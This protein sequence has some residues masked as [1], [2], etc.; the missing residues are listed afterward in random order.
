MPVSSIDKIIL[1]ERPAALHYCSQLSL[2]YK[3]VVS[4]Y[5]LE[6]RLRKGS[7]WFLDDNHNKVKN[8]PLSGGVFRFDL[9]SDGVTLVAAL[10][11]GCI[12]TVNLES[13]SANDLSV[14]I[15]S[16]LLSVCISEERLLSSD[17][18]GN[19]HVIDL[20]SEKVVSF[21]AA[22]LKYTNEPCE[23][24]C[25]AWHNDG[26]YI[27]SGG[28]DALLK[29][30]DVRCGCESVGCNSSHESGVT[31][32]KK[33]DEF[34]LLTGSYD[35]NIRRFDYRYFDKPLCQKMLDGG[36]WSIEEIGESK[37]LAACMY[38]GWVLLDKNTFSIMERKTDSGDFILYGATECGD[39]SL[40]ASCTFKNYTV[41][42]DKITD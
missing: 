36:V 29:L 22:W 20:P 5:E 8:L 32:V 3:L 9:F 40:I 10:T 37:L 14:S 17:N 33:E 11:N 23:V 42:F 38:N 12:S 18:R 7:L 26:R 25:T 21:P 34:H 16:M 19:V 1:P 27:F 30:W 4:T 35:E 39:P 24:W 28:E 2:P 41:H 6:S 15:D 13:L 31:F